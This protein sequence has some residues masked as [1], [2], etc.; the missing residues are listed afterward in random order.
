MAASLLRLGG[1]ILQLDAWSFRAVHPA[2]SLCTKA[3]RPKKEPTKNVVAAEK[4]KVQV[5]KRTVKSP[6]QS[7]P[8]SHQSTGAAGETIAGIKSRVADQ[9]VA[10]FPPRKTLVEFPPRAPF[11]AVEGAVSASVAKSQEKKTAEEKPSSSI[12]SYSRSS[13]SDS[14]SSSDS[15][16]EQDAAEVPVKTRVEFP[17][18]GPTCTEMRDEEG[19]VPTAKKK[20]AIHAR[21]DLTG[22]PAGPPR[23]F[24]R[25]P[26]GDS[27][28][29][30]S[31][32]TKLDKSQ[33]T[34]STPTIELRH[35]KPVAKVGSSSGAPA[36]PAPVPGPTKL[37]VVKK[38]ARVVG[39]LERPPAKGLPLENHEEVLK[40]H[41]P[42]VGTEA[43][44][45][46]PIQ[47]RSMQSASLDTKESVIS[48]DCANPGDEMVT[49]P[50]TESSSVPGVTFE[51]VKP[52]ALSE[53]ADEILE[54]R[55]EPDD[56]ATKIQEAST[57][58]DKATEIQEASTIP[59]KATEIQEAST[60]PDKAAEIQKAS[61]IPDKATEIQEASTIPDKATEIQEA[62][63]IPDKAAEIQKASTIPEKTAEILETQLS[64]DKATDMSEPSSTVSQVDESLDSNL[65][66]SK[67]PGEQSP[68]SEAITETEELR[69]PQGA[70]A[71]AGVQEEVFDN[72]TYRNLQHHSFTPFTFI[73]IDVELSKFRL[74]QP[75]SGRPSPQH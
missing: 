13:E 19:K 75:S 42:V 54:P 2:I 7:S 70:E 3:G 21:P 49:P 61:T 51:I 24:H 30:I 31:P 63:T 25:S 68:S 57:I 52:R 44:T 29:S 39:N 33:G 35:A 4:K 66:P 14:S 60:I 17:V 62:S 37:K 58:P 9:G 40:G 67:D 32:L 64:S 18:Q 43:I 15:E 26:K 50:R 59:D 34:I 20:K 23:D 53:I 8:S 65:T 38:G 12:T 72:S 56:K 46:K 1:K 55:T 74:P 6:K 45:E 47:D 73:D 11:S 5:D 28:P 71:A 16:G 41:A 36:A 10:Q 27:H 22:L 48:Q 69:T